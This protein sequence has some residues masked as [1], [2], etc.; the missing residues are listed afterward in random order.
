M[1]PWKGPYT[2]LE[3]IVDRVY[4]VSLNNRG[5]PR[6]VHRDHFEP[7][8]GQ[9]P[10]PSSDEATDYENDD[11][12]DPMPMARPPTKSTPTRIPEVVAYK[13]H[14]EVETNISV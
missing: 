2:I 6:V 7:L 3:V 11:G 14:K 8:R 1:R 10:V 4:K 12:D 9:N 5:K 13:E